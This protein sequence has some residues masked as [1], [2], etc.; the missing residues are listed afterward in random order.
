M[1][2]LPS[3]VSPLVVR[4]DFTDP[5]T[6]RAVR[7]AIVA[8][9]RDHGYEFYANV[10][11]L[12]NQSY[13]GM[14][15]AQLLDLARA[16]YGHP[17]LVLADDLTMRS[18]DHPLLVIAAGGAEHGRAFRAVP[19]AIQGIENNLSIANMDFREFAD[20][21]GHDGIFRGF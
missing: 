18:V 5:A 14:T 19:T 10:E 2:P 16:R 11:F 3:A 13:Q 8:P 9:V 15:A 21:V 6:W 1:Q 7:L 17:F 4:T 12:D 20:A